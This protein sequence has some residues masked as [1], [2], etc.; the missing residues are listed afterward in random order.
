MYT[1]YWRWLFGTQISVVISRISGNIFTGKKCFWEGI[2]GLTDTL[3]IYTE[4]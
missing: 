3:D 2:K 1:V 4:A